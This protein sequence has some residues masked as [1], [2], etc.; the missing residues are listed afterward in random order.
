MQPSGDWSEGTPLR[1]YKYKGDVLMNTALRTGHLSKATHD[2]VQQIVHEINRAP[3]LRRD[4]YVYRGIRDVPELRLRSLK[5]GDVLIDRG[6]MSMSIEPLMARYFMAKEKCCLFRIVLPP[7]TKAVYEGVERTRQ[8]PGLG[9]GGKRQFVSG[10]TESELLTYPGSGLVILAVPSTK[11]PMYE[12]ELLPT[13]YRFR[14]NGDLVLPPY[15]TRLD[16]LVELILEDAHD[17]QTIVFRNEKDEPVSFIRWETNP[18]AQMTYDVTVGA[19]VPLLL[20]PQPI[21]RYWDAET[22]LWNDKTEARWMRPYRFEP[23][24]TSVA[25]EIAR[26]RRSEWYERCAPL[27]FPLP[28]PACETPEYEP[29]LSANPAFAA[30]DDAPSSPPVWNPF[31]TEALESSG[32]ETEAEEQQPSPPPAKRQKA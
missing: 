13:T 15:D 20:P 31:D 4:V 1:F 28:P 3:P 7:G 23:L 29:T 5:P 27:P 30:T 17:G 9:E 21:F 14:A 6:F 10:D 25:T 12:A 16:E 18:Y 8:K 11:S 19:H 26:G 24:L 22:N 32:S 2:V